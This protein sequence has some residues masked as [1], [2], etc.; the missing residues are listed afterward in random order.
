MKLIIILLIILM[1]LPLSAHA[2]TIKGSVYDLS[3]EK[4]N[5]AILEID[6]PRQQVISSNGEY[7]FNVGLGPYTIIARQLKGGK[8]VANASEKISLD[9]EGEF[10]LDIV[11]FPVFDDI[12]LSD[13]DLDKQENGLQIELMLGFVAVILIAMILFLIVFKR[14]KKEKRTV[15][16][17][18]LAETPHESDETKSEKL[19]EDLQKALGFIKEQ[20]GRVNQKDIKH[21]M[22]LSDAKISLMMD[23]LEG[24]GIVKR[25]KKGR[26][27]VISLNK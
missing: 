14:R 1:L 2:A 8:L 6:N 4:V 10:N 7:S 18:S 27:N 16:N 12:S 19:P 5:G 15:E 13:V 25:I 23:D 21:H 17:N 3:L 9:K 24:R 22:N 26:A 20:G 11:L